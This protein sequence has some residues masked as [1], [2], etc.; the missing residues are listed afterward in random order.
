MADIVGE[1]LSQ[2]KQKYLPPLSRIWSQPPSL[3]RHAWKAADGPV[4]LPIPAAWEP[5]SFI[6]D[7]TSI[8]CL[9]APVKDPVGCIYILQ[10]F[11][12]VSERYVNFVNAANALGLPVILTELPNPGK[13]TKYMKAYR[14]IGQ[15]HYLDNTPII[16][17]YEHFPIYFMPHSTGG[18]IETEFLAKKGPSS[19]IIDKSKGSV[20]SAPFYIPGF[21]KKKTLIKL[22]EAYAWAMPDAHY[23]DTLADQ[24]HAGYQRLKG[25]PRL[26]PKQHRPTQAQIKY[27][28]KKCPPVLDR[29][30]K[31][32]FSQAVRDYQILGIAGMNDYV[33][34][35]GTI[36]WVLEQMHSG[37]IVEDSGWHTM[38]LEREDVQSRILKA[39]IDDI[40]GTQ[41]LNSLAIVNGAE[42]PRTQDLH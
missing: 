7:G 34:H 14:K 40:H 38:H 4:A 15:A 26:A 25:R 11:K 19:E 13:D 31:K 21:A 6:V 22:Q 36:L 8:R 27:M 10:G 42:T 18:T 28:A 41:S 3:L 33:A 20:L 35:P 9:H 37:F 30:L 17:E 16:R 1:P 12:D 24:F 2:Q 39:I 5:L 23:G 29:I 32:G